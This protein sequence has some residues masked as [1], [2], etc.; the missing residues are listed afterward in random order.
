VVHSIEA[1]AAEIN[2]VR[3]PK[4]TQRGRKTKSWSRLPPG[5]LKLNCDAA[6]SEDSKSG[7]WGWII[8]DSDTLCFLR[9]V[10]C[11]YYIKIGKE[12]I[13]TLTTRKQD[14]LQSTKTSSKHP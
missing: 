4:A 11:T 3:T 10:P 8:R 9:S 12:W 2:K 14:M 13:Q 7:G 5:V 1:Y 6:F